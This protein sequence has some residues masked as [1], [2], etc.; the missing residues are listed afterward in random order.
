[1]DNDGY[2]SKVKSMY[3]AGTN[4]SLGKRLVRE[5]KESTTMNAEYLSVFGHV[6]GRDYVRMTVSLYDIDSEGNLDGTNLYLLPFT[7]DTKYY[8]YNSAKNAV[9][10]T[11]MN[12]IAG[13][14]N[15]KTG[16]SKIFA[17]ASEGK[18]KFV[19]IVK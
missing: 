1:M 12:S 19:M 7:Q 9:E 11:L 8:I 13:Y 2:V 15:T 18:T 6:Y 14:S 10:P 5:G 16:A 3:D 17:Y 4:P